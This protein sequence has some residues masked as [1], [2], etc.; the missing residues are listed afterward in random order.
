M[1]ERTEELKTQHVHI[2]KLQ[3]EL[4]KMRDSAELMAAVK[5]ADAEKDRKLVAKIKEKVGAE[6]VN[7]TK[8]GSNNPGAVI[9]R[10][11]CMLPV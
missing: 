4:E 10:T 5:E 7:R 8:L 2:D 11:G 6:F 3:D 1:E 9:N